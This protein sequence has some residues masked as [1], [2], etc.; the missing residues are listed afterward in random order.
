MNFSE[1]GDP[2]ERHEVRIFRP[3]G[4]WNASAQLLDDQ[5]VLAER[6][7][8]HRDF[9]RGAAGPGELDMD[10][11]F[12]QWRTVR[13]LSSSRSFRAALRAA[14]A[15]LPVPQD[16]A[17]ICCGACPVSP[18]RISSLVGSTPRTSISSAAM[19]LRN[20]LSHLMAGCRDLTRPLADRRRVVTAA[21]ID[22][23]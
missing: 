7:R 21:V 11:F 9:Q 20:A 2:A 19:T 17:V 13:T 5:C 10:R 1:M 8:I 22:P 14:G 16:P 18:I 12:R 4:G 23:L 3:G 6:Y 15:T